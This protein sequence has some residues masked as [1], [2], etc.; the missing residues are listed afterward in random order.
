M[1]APSASSVLHSLASS[2]LSSPRTNGSPHLRCVYVG[3]VRE[4]D[5]NLALR[6]TVTSRP[7]SRASLRRITSVRSG[8]ACLCRGR[9]N[10]IWIIYHRHSGKISS[11]SGTTSAS[12]FRYVRCA[13]ICRPKP[14]PCGILQFQQNFECLWT[15]CRNERVA[16]TGT[17]SCYSVYMLP[18]KQA[19]KKYTCLL[20]HV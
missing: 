5:F 18:T 4:R 15:P 3:L 13:I 12:V 1:T 20:Y 14:S 10:W 6:T 19:P 16:D 11:F 2:T 7:M 9:S 17:V 8:T